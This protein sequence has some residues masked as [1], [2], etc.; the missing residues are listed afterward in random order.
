MHTTYV[1]KGAF[2]FVDGDS[3]GR[4]GCDSVGASEIGECALD[5]C[6]S[7]FLVGKSL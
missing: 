1:A 4:D 3:A 7:I 2:K 5:M 6:G